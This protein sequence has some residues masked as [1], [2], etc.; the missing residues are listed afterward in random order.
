MSE[1][2]RIIWQY[3]DSGLENAPFVVQICSESWVS[4][5]PGWRYVFLDK[6]SV[7]QYVPA[8]R[9]LPMEKYPSVQKYTNHVRLLLLIEHGGVWADADVYCHEPLDDW[10]SGL[11]ESGVFM[12]SDP[13]PTRPISNWFICNLQP[14]T[15]RYLFEVLE[16]KYRDYFVLNNFH[17]SIWAK[18]LSMI[19]ERLQAKM[20]KAGLRRSAIYGFWTSKVM[21]RILRLSPYFIFHYT[22]AFLEDTDSN[23]RFIS[24]GIKKVSASK[25]LFVRRAYDRNAAK[26]TELLELM[27]FTP[28]SKLSYRT[29]N[30]TNSHQWLSS[31]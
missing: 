11:S 7:S 21:S 9:L 1:S 31:L 24:Q 26:A 29:M 15:G 3:W 4:K 19:I 5:N 8:N 30:S 28:V 23:F 13:G 10:T 6:D 18:R 27:S 22:Y 16:K 20:V 12:F 14:S 2:A 17:S 25:A